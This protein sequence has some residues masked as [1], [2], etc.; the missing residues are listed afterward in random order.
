MHD[1]GIV[2]GDLRGV[3]FWTLQLLSWTQLIPFPGQHPNQQQR[4]RLYTRLQPGHDG[5]GSVNLYI[6]TLRG[7]RSSMDE[8][9]TH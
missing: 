4:P 5:L 1:Q 7:W 6:F 3:C 8:S 9:G 2:H